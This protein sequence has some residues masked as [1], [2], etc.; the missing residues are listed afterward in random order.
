MN[1]HTQKPYTCRGTAS[2]RSRVLPALLI[3]LGL[4]LTG[5]VTA[6]TFKTL[7]AFTFSDGATP[8]SELVLS[9]G[10]LYGTASAG[11]NSG[12]YNGNGTLFAVNTDGSGFTNEYIFTAYPPGFYPTNTDGSVPFAGLILSSNTL[13]GAAYD[14]GV[15]GA[16]TVFAVN[17]NNGS[18]F[19]NLYSFTGGNDGGGPDAALVLSSNT[20]YGTTAYGGGANNGTVFAINTDGTGFT[21]LFN[22]T[23][24]ISGSDPAGVLILSG[25][26]LYGTTSGGN[27]GFGTVFAINTDGSSFTNLHVFT[28][29]SGF[30]SYTNSDGSNPNAGLVLSGRTLYGAAA[31]G[32]RFGSGT[33]FAVNTN[34][35]G[36]TNL[37]TFTATSG[38]PLTN[39]DG[40]NPRGSLIVSGGT[41][42][43]TAYNGGRFG[44]GTLFAISTNGS[45]F[46]NLYTFTANSTAPYTN[47]D[48]AHPNAALLLSGNTLFGTA[49][50]GGNP[51]TN[52]EY[53][54]V[55]SFTFASIS[56]PLLAIN[57][58]GTNVI[59]T[60]PTN[61][62]GFTLEST[63]NLMA[64]AVWITNAT[65]PAIVN[66]NNAVTNGITGTQKFY[67]LSQ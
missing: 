56:P 20:L 12:S 10:T 51:G 58:S 57:P 15:F 19:T 67:R 7:H 25:R 26:T 11:G 35:S 16:G 37:Y 32:G 30:P 47:S 44:S 1:T 2:M 14:G 48:G 21:N 61:A 23:N 33:L 5:P 41:L 65:A 42:Y 43:G 4:L 39:S 8:Y 62:T 66:T 59:L 6:Q 17:T 27:G 54:T 53:G 60:W 64:P 49:Y 36:F 18:S 3:V 55:F 52:V 34:G 38:T 46:T 40:S 9:G 31:Q 13:Y 29:N 28:A 22:F 63:T 24:G 45:G 50:N